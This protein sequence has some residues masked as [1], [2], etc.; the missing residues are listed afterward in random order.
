MGRRRASS[1]TAAGPPSPARYPGSDA[2]EP[3]A[4]ITESLGI[5]TLGIGVPALLAFVPEKV[6]GFSAT[7]RPDP[8]VPGPTPRGSAGVRRRD[9]PGGGSACPVMRSWPRRPCRTGWPAANPAGDWLTLS[10]KAADSFA[11]TLQGGTPARAGSGGGRRSAAARTTTGL[12]GTNSRGGHHAAGV[13]APASNSQSPV[14]GPGRLPGLRLADA[15]GPRRGLGGTAAATP[16]ATAGAGI[17]RPGSRDRPRPAASWVSAGPPRREARPQHGRRA[18][19]PRRRPGPAVVPLLHDVH[20][21]QP[22]RHGPLPRA[23]PVRHVRRGAVDLSRLGRRRDRVLL[24]LVLQRGRHRPA[25][26]SPAPIPISS[27]RLGQQRRGVRP[28]LHRRGRPRSHR[29]QRPRPG[30]DL[31][32]RPRQRGRGQ[33]ER[34]DLARVAGA[35]RGPRRHRRGSV[36]SHNVSVASVSGASTPRSRCPPTIPTSRPSAWSTTR[37]PPTRC[38]SSPSTTRSTRRWPSRPRSALPSSRSAGSRARR[39]TTTPAALNP[40]DIQQIALQAGSHRTATGRYA[41]S[42]AIGDIRGTT[43]TTTV[44]GTL[45]VLNESG[46]VPRATAGRLAG[47]EQVIRTGRRDPRPGRRRPGRS[48]SPAAPAPAAGRTPT[49]RASSRPWSRIPAA[50]TPTRSPTAPRSTSTRP[51][52]WRQSSVDRNGLRT[53]FAYT[54]GNLTTITDP[55]SNVTTFTYDGSGRAVRADHRPAGRVAAVTSIRGPRKPEPA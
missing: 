33:Q 14:L 24:R 48:G 15:A 50:P 49:R 19:H 18:C 55:Y 47:L 44:T 54:S 8:P 11:P 38:R 34:D 2:L 20:R 17:R 21:R 45:T 46:S 7:P 37:W 41:Y 31:H 16:A 5:L 42:L 10:R 43:T 22:G 12:G 51:P 39:T 13:A 35:G 27:V 9:A 40:G 3:R 52:A 53:T 4:M 25:D 28:L 30:P 23:R 26:Q 1:P 6:E 36:A 32:L 29:H